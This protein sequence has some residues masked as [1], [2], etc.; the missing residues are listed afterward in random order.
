MDFAKQLYPWIDFRVWDLNKP[1]SL[2]ADS[3]VCVEAFEHV[4]D[5]NLAM[6]NPLE[7]A[8]HELWISTPNNSNHD[9]NPP[10]NP[11]HIAEYSIKEMLAIIHENS[12]CPIS[13]DILDWETF[14]PI[15]SGKS[16]V[17]PV[18]YWI[19]KQ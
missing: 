13:I 6:R 8:N 4:A 19:R 11:Y 5:P 7:A 10:D 18:V 3:V 2:R 15:E 17:S 12:N 16:Q 9:R 14:K 1:T